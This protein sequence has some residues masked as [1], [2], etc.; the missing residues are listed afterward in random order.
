MTD[1]SMRFRYTVHPSIT[2]V[3]EAGDFGTEASKLALALACKLRAYGVNN[4]GIQS[5]SAK[6]NGES[7][8]AETLFV[9]RTQN[10]KL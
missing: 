10:N 6:R 3:S 5:M 7:C 1:S 8:R 2:T 4:N 9:I